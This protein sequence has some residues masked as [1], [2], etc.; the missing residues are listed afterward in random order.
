LRQINDGKQNK[1]KKRS[2]FNSDRRCDSGPLELGEELMIIVGGGR[3]TP[4]WATVGEKFM[5]KKVIGIAVGTILLALSCSVQA[6]RPGEIPRVG[7]LFMGGRDQPHLEAFKQGLR[8]LGYSEGKNIILEYRY[9]GA[10]IT[11]GGSG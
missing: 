8:E 2:V 7:I 9:A 11:A 5:S 6:Q 3:G 10:D 1:M 4:A